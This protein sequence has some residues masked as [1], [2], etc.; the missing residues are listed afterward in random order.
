MNTLN[1]GTSCRVRRGMARR[2]VA[3]TLLAA[4]VV[5]SLSPRVH[6]GCDPTPADNAHTI[7]TESKNAGLGDSDARMLIGIAGCESGFDEGALSGTGN[8]GL[9][10]IGRAAWD[11]AGTGYSFDASKF[12]PTA[13]T[14]VAVRLHQKYGWSPMWKCCGPPYNPSNE[15]PYLLYALDH[16]KPNL[17]CGCNAALRAAGYGSLATSTCY[18]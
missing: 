10:Q 8:A 13:N 17:P 12:D 9:F 16:L 1:E 6:A 18:N 11:A 4:I 3:T 7:W 14:R 5:A 2:R 15:D